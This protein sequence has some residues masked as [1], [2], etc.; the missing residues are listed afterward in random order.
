M[1]TFEVC[2]RTLLGN[3]IEE[4][5]DCFLVSDAIEQFMQLHSG[6]MSRGIIDT[7]TIKCR[8][9]NTH[10]NT[11]CRTNMKRIPSNVYVE[12]ITISR[13]IINF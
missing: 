6:W 9:K 10:K 8:K 5:I 11:L 1:C 2:A 7:R 13:T 3:V 4:T 12:R